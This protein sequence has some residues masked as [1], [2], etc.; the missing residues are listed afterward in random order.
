MDMVRAGVMFSLR[1][2]SCWRVEVVKGGAGVRLFSWRFTLETEK[3]PCSTAAMTA[4]VSASLASSIFLS[5]PW[6][7]ALKD[8]ALGATRP[9]SAS[10][11]QYSWGWK[12]RISSSRS[13]TSRVATDWTR[14]ADRP[15]RIFR[16]SRG[17]SW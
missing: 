9:R 17:E 7:W 4:S 15:R 14:P 12:A 6:N 1:E 16:H 11:V 5:R 2:A 13:T 10:M 8:P 3:V